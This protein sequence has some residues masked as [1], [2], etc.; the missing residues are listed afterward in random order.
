MA[1]DLREGDENISALVFLA[2]T[3]V[4]LYVIAGFM[5]PELFGGSANS[6]AASPVPTP[7]ADARENK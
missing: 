4:V 3:L 2:G 5:H 6:D 1:L 7:A